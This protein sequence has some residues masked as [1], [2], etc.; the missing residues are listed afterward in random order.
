MS[1]E[2]SYYESIRRKANHAQERLKAT[3]EQSRIASA[4]ADLNRAIDDGAGA[5]PPRATSSHRSASRRAVRS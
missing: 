1:D 5:S 4:A 2:R 3:L